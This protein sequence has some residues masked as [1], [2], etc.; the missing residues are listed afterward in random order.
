LIWQGHT[1]LPKVL[2]FEC[3]FLR[4]HADNQS[5]GRRASIPT[6]SRT[7]ATLIA[8]SCQNRV[9][10]DGSFFNASRVISATLWTRA[11]AGLEVLTGLTLIVAPS[12]LARFLFGSDLNAAGEATGRISGFVMLCLA[13]GC[14]PRA[15]ER[16]RHQALVPLVA[17]SWLAVAFLVVTGL[18]GTNVGLLLWPA[19]ALHLILAVLLTWTWARAPTT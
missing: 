5:E 14:W 19:A 15:G 7:A 11:A 9:S 17:L 1:D 10:M 12:V 18:T 8:G 4:A 2:I 13:A 3:R 6:F 16:S